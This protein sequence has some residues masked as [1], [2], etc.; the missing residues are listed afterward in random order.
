LDLIIRP[1]TLD[2]TADLQ[3]F[4]SKLFGEDLPGIFR[5]P[6]PTLDEEAAFIRT[7]IEPA[8]STILVATIDGSVV[9]LLDFLGGSLQEETHAGTFA[10]SVDGDHRGQ[11]I[12]TALLEALVAWAPPHG[13]TRIQAWAWMSNPRALVL[14]ERLGFEREGLC[15]SALMV[16]G[17]PVDVVLVARLLVD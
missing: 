2:D 10:L 15:R 11:G 14:Y 16:D 9:G 13:I 12:G 6:V 5:R 3:R 4:A 1:A 7:H 17:Q 8:N